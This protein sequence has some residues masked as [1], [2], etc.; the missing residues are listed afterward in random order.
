MSRLTFGLTALARIARGQPR[1]CPF[2]DGTDSTVIGREKLILELRQCNACFLKFRYPKDEPVA[3]RAYY[4]GDYQGGHVT[5][6]PGDDELAGARAQGYRGSQWDFAPKIDYVKSVHPG[7]RLLDFGCSWGYVVEQFGAAGYDAAG[8]EISRPRANFGRER[9]DVSIFD[10]YAQLERLDDGAFD[11]IFT[12]HVLEHLPDI[13]PAFALFKRLL[14]RDGRLV[15]IVPNGDGPRARELGGAVISQEHVT[16]LDARF[17]ATNL[18]Q[19]G[20]MPQFC[21]EPY[22]GAC[23]GYD[24]VEQAY[25]GLQGLELMAVAWH[26]I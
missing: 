3:A 13:K 6:L 8:F 20:L 7:P 15:I 5:D 10:E 21:S 4:E 17:F 24:S 19:F 16:S 22:G 1:T 18:P 14:A 2:C 9:L 23:I 26:A 12:N 25:A 11:V